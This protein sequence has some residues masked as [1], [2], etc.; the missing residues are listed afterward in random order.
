[1]DDRRY[2]SD[3]GQN[4]SGSTGFLSRNSF[5]S[6]EQ[7]V[8]PLWIVLAFII[9]GSIIYF[10]YMYMMQRKADADAV[11]DRQ[12]ANANRLRDKQEVQGYVEI[13]KQAGVFSQ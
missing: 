2:K 4:R 10:A 13:A 3:Y 6:P 5:R 12:T 9:V 11:R 7:S 8:N 1:M